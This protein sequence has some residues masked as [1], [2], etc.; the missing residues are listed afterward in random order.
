MIGS[1]KTGVVLVCMAA[2]AIGGCALVRRHEGR[3][4]GDML[5]AA[6]F[7]PTPADTPEQ[8]RRLRAMPA[9]TIVSETTNGS[10]TYRF[11]DPYGCG[12]L[13]V[14]GQKAYGTYNQRRLAKRVADQQLQDVQEQNMIAS[15]SAMSSWD[16][17]AW[18]DGCPVGWWY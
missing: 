2:H 17:A 9:L 14:G 7:R 6:G 8:Q 12:C 1:R 5:I 3:A 4:T 13:Y 16:W 10:T 15:E 18:N 11:A